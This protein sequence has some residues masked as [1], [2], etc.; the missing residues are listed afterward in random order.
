MKWNQFLGGLL[1]GGGLGLM[2]GG[3][4]VQ[5]PQDGKGE[6][7][8]PVFLSMLLTITGV[9]VAGIGRR[10]SGPSQHDRVGDGDAKSPQ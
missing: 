4:I 3:A 5:L 10:R 7:V 2:V 8:Y 9:G 6:R 1:V